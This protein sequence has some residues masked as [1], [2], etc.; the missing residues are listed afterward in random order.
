MPKWPDHRCSWANSSTC[1][2][3]L[4]GTTIWYTVLKP[5]P[6][7]SVAAPVC[8]DHFRINTP[9]STR[10]HWPSLHSLESATTAPKHFSSEGVTSLCTNESFT[11]Q[12]QWYF[13][14][15]KSLWPYFT[16]LCRLSSIDHPVLRKNR[17]EH[18]V[19]QSYLLIFLPSLSSSQHADWTQFWMCLNQ[20]IWL[21]LRNGYIHNLRVRVHF[22]SRNVVTHDEVY[23][24]NRKTWSYSY[25][26]PTR[27]KLRL[28]VDAMKWGWHITHTNTSDYCTD[29]T[30][31]F[32]I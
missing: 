20:F 26:E 23:S 17:R 19:R 1:L 27:N 13:R 9:F 31:W 22:T 29:I 4:T 30:G 16:H 25:R 10:K 28:N 11:C 2:R 6:V 3:Q 21:I 14:S 24:I 12:R 18:G 7:S 5:S 8:E 15:G 32:S